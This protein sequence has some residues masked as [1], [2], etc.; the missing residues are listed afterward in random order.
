MPFA[1]SQVICDAL[2]AY[3]WIACDEMQHLLLGC[4]GLTAGIT[5][6]IVARPNGKWEAYPVVGFGHPEFNRIAVEVEVGDGKK[7]VVYPDLPY[8]AKCDHDGDFSWYCNN[9]VHGDT[10]RIRPRIGHAAA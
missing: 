1:H 6:I 4:H 2:C 9:Y 3:F 7:E 10:A 8:V 5:D